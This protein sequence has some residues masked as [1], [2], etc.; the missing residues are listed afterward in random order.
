MDW[1]LKAWVSVKTLPPETKRS[2]F[3]GALFVFV[4][5]LAY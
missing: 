4:F 2:I 5:I 1:L 3:L